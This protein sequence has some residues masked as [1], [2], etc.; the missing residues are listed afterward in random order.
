[1]RRVDTTVPARDAAGRGARGGPTRHRTASCVTRWNGTR[2]V[3]D[4]RHAQPAEGR[5]VRR[6][7]A[8]GR[9][10][11]AGLAAQRA[12]HGSALRPPCMLQWTVRYCTGAL[13]RPR[14]ASCRPEE[15]IV[16]RR[17]ILLQD[18]RSGRSKLRTRL[19][20][21]RDRTQNG[22]S[23]ATRRESPLWK[24]V[25]CSWHQTPSVRA[26]PSTTRRHTRSRACKQRT[27][28]RSKPRPRPRVCWTTRALSELQSI[29]RRRDPYE[30]DARFQNRL[31]N[32]AWWNAF[33]WGRCAA[34][35]IARL[36]TTTTSSTKSGSV[37]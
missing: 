35:A 1:M 28:R 5:G 15:G 3:D 37:I 16:Q 9:D 17:H 26:R 34:H 25:A 18:S 23:T 19:R 7:V 13:L 11:V 29:R 4:G 24:R 12:A 27:T 10:G 30:R 33:G 22:L 21:A 31:G 8:A 2:R 20:A 32:H 36:T 6:V 14:A